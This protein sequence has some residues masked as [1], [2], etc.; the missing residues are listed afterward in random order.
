MNISDNA[1]VVL[2]KRYLTRDEHNN[3]IETVEQVFRLI[4]TA[5]GLSGC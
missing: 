1:R 4:R 5:R 2:E 3:V